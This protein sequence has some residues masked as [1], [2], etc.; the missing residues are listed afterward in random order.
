VALK[1][2]SS[3]VDE[4]AAKDADA[5]LPS[6]PAASMVAV[7]SEALRYNEVVTMADI[8]Q[9]TG[10]MTGND[11]G[12]IKAQM[13]RFAF[14]PYTRDDDVNFPMCKTCASRGLKCRGS[15]PF[16]AC[17]VCKK[18]HLRCS[19]CKRGSS[20]SMSDRLF[21]RRRCSQGLPPWRLCASWS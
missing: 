13:T 16:A 18:G 6:A 19:N 8:E 10:L 11:V 9:V 4:G 15:G 5:D 3:G 7:N 2:Y 20:R 21:V 12:G 14:A 17:E 1:A